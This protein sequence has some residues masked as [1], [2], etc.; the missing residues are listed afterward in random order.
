MKRV[1]VVEDDHDVNTLICRYLGQRS[2]HCDAAQS[3]AQAL[4][5]LERPGSPDLIL[6]DLELPDMDGADLAVEI[7]RRAEHSHIPV[8][9]MTGY[10]QE[11][12]LDAFREA[13]IDD[14]LFKPFNPKDLLAKVNEMT[15][16]S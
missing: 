8:L 7:K 13:G 16:A 3:A 9:V 11:S 15:Q 6:M 2:Y 5:Q 4:E 1:L 14:Y 10:Q 12:R